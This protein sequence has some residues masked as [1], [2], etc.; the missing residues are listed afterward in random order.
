MEFEWDEQKARSNCAKHRIDFDEARTIFDG[1][2]ISRPDRR[3]DYGELRHVAV[4]KLAN[5]TA[6][7]VAYTFRAD[8]IRIIMARRANRYE[9]RALSQTN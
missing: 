2:Y 9:R 3:F 1:F 7:A 4:G 8:R 6:V 5:G